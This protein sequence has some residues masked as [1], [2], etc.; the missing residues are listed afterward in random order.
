MLQ[1]YFSI[2]VVIVCSTIGKS[3]A[4]VYPCW[5]SLS[6]VVNHGKCSGSN[7]GSFNIHA[8]A[9]T[10]TPNPPTTIRAYLFNPNG[11]VRDSI[12]A[13]P[14]TLNYGWLNLPPG[15]YRVLIYQVNYANEYICHSETFPVITEPGCDLNINS[16]N[17]NQNP[18]DSQ[19]LYVNGNISGTFCDYGYEPTFAL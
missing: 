2:L 13:S 1:K 8:D 12:I 19:F 10:Y 9:N 11:A 18:A 7:T 14:N 16:M 6:I 3:S 15:N 5:D 4:Q 17:V